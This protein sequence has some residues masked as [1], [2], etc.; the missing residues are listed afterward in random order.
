MSICL[1]KK[2]RLSILFESVQVCCCSEFKCQD[3]VPPLRTLYTNGFNCNSFA[4]CERY[5]QLYVITILVSMGWLVDD[6]SVRWVVDPPVSLSWV[7]TTPV[8]VGLVLRCLTSRSL[9][10]MPEIWRTIFQF[11][12]NT[13]CTDMSHKM[14][15]YILPKQVQG[16]ESHLGRSECDVL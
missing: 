4:T 16:S 8:S 5:Y 2:K 11:C 12:K 15:V 1:L 14:T 7:A 6:V 10:V 3:C 9:H 13:I